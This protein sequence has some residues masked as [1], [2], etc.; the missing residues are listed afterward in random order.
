MGHTASPPMVERAYIESIRQ[1]WIRGIEK[2]G[3]VRRVI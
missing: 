1:V 3:V 2:P